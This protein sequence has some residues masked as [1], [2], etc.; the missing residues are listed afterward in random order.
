MLKDSL[1]CFSACMR[2]MEELLQAEQPEIDR[3]EEILSEMERQLYIKTATYALSVWE[4]EFGIVGNPGSTAEQRRAAVLGKLN[5]RTPATVGMIE[6]LVRQTMGAE[7]VEIIEHPEEYR[8]EVHVSVDTLTGSLAVAKKAVY[9]ARPAHLGYRFMEHLI[10]DAAVDVYVGVMGGSTHKS[11]ATV[12]MGRLYSP[13]YIA[14][15]GKFIGV[16]K[17]SVL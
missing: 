3:L 14:G 4:R 2:D 10:R 5:T 8:F 16:R 11:Y 15:K 7:R 13:V 17:G 12:D 6:N 9:H 1:P